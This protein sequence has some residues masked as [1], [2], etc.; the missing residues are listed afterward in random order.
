[1]NRGNERLTEEAERLNQYLSQYRYCIEK[2]RALEKRRLEVVREFEHPLNPRRMDGMPGGSSRQLGCAALPLKLDEIDIRIKAQLEYT[3]QV[4]VNIM[5]VIDFLPKN[6]M[7]RAIIENR[8]IDRY[9]WE[10][11]CLENHIS[12]T[13]ATKKWR[14]GLYMLLERMEVREILEKYY[15]EQKEK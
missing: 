9:N 12:R 1:M 11:V 14:N 15:T 4:L 2:K 10:K 7:E 3:K 8:Y 13:P 5:D 6:S